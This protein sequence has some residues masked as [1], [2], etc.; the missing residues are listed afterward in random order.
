MLLGL[1]TRE[2]GV[3]W[4][5]RE[6]GMSQGEAQYG[7]LTNSEYSKKGTL[8]KEKRIIKKKRILGGRGAVCSSE[9]TFLLF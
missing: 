6:A 8:R 7:A 9:R 4:G 2:P 3:G 1:S 5:K